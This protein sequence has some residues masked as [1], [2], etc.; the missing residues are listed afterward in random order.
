MS[1]TK[2]KYSLKCA[3][4]TPIAEKLAN[5]TCTV[6]FRSVIFISL[7]LSFQIGL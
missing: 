1:D 2:V 4:L 6:S 7:W 3:T 5:P